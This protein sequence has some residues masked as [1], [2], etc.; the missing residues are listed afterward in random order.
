MI[1]LWEFHADPSRKKRSN[2]ESH[3][4]RILMR[5]LFPESPEMARHASQL[6]LCMFLDTYFHVGCVTPGNVV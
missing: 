6:L 5:V 2:S 1:S 4:S 3:D